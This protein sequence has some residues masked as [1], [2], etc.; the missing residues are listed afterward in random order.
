MVPLRFEE[1]W[2]KSGGNVF[3]GVMSHTSESLI[4]ESELAV[5]GKH[6]LLEWIV[7]RISF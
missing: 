3:S 4:E 2:R 7:L 1:M 6:H 5:P